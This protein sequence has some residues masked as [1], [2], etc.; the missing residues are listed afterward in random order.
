MTQTISET[1]IAAAERLL[2]LAY[3][4]RERTQMRDNLDGQRDAAV[5]RRA[6]RLDDNTPPAARFDPRLPGFVMPCGAD[7]LTLSTI[8]TALPS[9]AEDI[10]F[11][12]LADYR[13]GSH[14]HLPRPD[15][16]AEPE[17]RVFRDRHA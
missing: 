17:A 14:Q 8:T 2:G 15:R 9:D 6:L 4:A 3:T 1:D 13:T 16:R 7:A 10:A 11:A 12:P 5:A